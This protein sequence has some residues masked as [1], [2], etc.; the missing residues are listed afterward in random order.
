[1]I[2]ASECP[3]PPGEGWDLSL[4]HQGDC[5][6]GETA[7][8]NVIDTTDFLVTLWILFLMISKPEKPLK[9]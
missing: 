4:A 8:F 7:A 2:R 5:R 3:G 1:M 6:R 9:I